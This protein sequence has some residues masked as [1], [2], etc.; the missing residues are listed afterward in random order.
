MIG[1]TT[2]VEALTAAEHELI[3]KKSAPM[4]SESM[5]QACSAIA[6]HWASNGNSIRAGVA[7]KLARRRTAN[8]EAA[9]TGSVTGVVVDEK[10]RPVNGALVYIDRVA[11]GSV[12]RP[13]RTDSYG[14]FSESGLEWGIYLVF[15]ESP[16]TDTRLMNIT[17][18]RWNWAQRIRMQM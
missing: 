14:R 10:N 1:K 16:V 17:R 9:A 13:Q 2:K 5:R 4:L 3:V 11:I 7:A 15:A 6:D 18:P 12:V 8:D